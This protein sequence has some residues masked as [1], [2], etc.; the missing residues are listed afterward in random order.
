MK[1][2]LLLFLLTALCPAIVWQEES[3]PQKEATGPM[4]NVG[5]LLYSPLRVLG[6]SCVLLDGRWV[7][8][9]RHGTEKWQADFLAVKFPALET[10]AL[11]IKAIHFP[12]T[13][14]FALLE[15]TEKVK[16]HESISL[17][18]EKT[19][20]QGRR[21][22]LG[23]FGKSG[24]VGDCH[25]HGVFR[26]GYNRIDQERGG[27][28]SCDLSPPGKGEEQ[29]VTVAQMDS[30]SPL[31]VET[32]QGWQLCGIASTA[33]NGKNPGYGNRSN[34]AKIA[35]ALGWLTPFLQKK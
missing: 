10:K 32:A 1:I 29:E 30:G 19:P 9:S 2:A 11:A 26:G 5:Q 16:E 31:F 34:Y 18:K 7:L 20:V 14:D 6:G 27:K 21:V 28:W 22:W 12:P 24:P 17:A 35:P 33:S 23:G 25:F 15:L 8:T 13:G 4:R 3:Q